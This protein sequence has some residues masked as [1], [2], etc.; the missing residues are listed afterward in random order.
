MSLD[1]LPVR[2]QVA[3]PK[4]EKDMHTAEFLFE[5][6]KETLLPDLLKRYIEMVLYQQF[7]ESYE[8]YNA[9]QMI[10]M[11]NATNN[12]KDIVNELQLLYNKARQEKNYE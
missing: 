9:A 10:A 3:D 5:P 11:Q 2:L 4:I 6:S 7:L 8:V 12:A 1:L